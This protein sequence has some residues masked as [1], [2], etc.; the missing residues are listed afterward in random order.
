MRMRYG[1][2]LTS[3]TLNAAGFCPLEAQKLECQHV[4]GQ[5]KHSTCSAHVKPSA[6]RNCMAAE[7]ASRHRIAGGTV[8]S[9]SNIPL[10]A[11]SNNSSSP[12]RRPT[13]FSWQRRKTVSW[14]PKL[15]ITPW[16]CQAL[17]LLHCKRAPD[18]HGLW[19]CYGMHSDCSE[20]VP[21]VEE[22]HGLAESACCP[23]GTSAFGMF[24]G[25]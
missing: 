22:R 14:K 23:L 24:S 17:C 8:Y 13:V 12:M 11:G 25:W 19:V 1:Q 3:Q 18:H 2:W 21:S 20:E 15:Y 7:E 9:S 4:S 6:H 16:W 10:F 5:S